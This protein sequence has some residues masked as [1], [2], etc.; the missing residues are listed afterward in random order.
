ML[1]GSAVGLARAVGYDGCMDEKA[2]CKRCGKVF[3]RGELRLPSLVLRV[4]AM[5][6][7]LP[8]LLKSSVV[9]HEFGA[10]YCRPC[11]RQLNVCFFFL[12]FVLVL[13]CALKAAQL[14]GLLGPVAK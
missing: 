1:A 3:D 9:Q 10:L 13:M 11:R 2:T 14:L 5:P 4:L 8:F 12:A 7:L 6:G